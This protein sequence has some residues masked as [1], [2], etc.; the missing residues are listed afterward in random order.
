VN[1][2]RLR[3]FTLCGVRRASQGRSMSDFYVQFLKFGIALVVLALVL[4]V[5]VFRKRW[6]ERGYRKGEAKNP[7]Q[8]K[9]E[10]PPD[11]LSRSH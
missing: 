8:V 11:E 7:G 9:R 4:T 6:F 10:N 5:I 1:I 3:A 2:A